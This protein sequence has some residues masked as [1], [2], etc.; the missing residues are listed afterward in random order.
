M[1]T[2]K[3]FKLLALIAA[4]AFS[5]ALFAVACKPKEV[6][7]TPAAPLMTPAT[8]VPAPVAP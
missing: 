4:L 6:V 3:T 1:E 5:L 2:I 8:E 7:P